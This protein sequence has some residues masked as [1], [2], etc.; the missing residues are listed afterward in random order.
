MSGPLAQ[1][2]HHTLL[3]RT[4]TMTDPFAHRPYSMEQQ[5]P[6][7]DGVTSRYSFGPNDLATLL[8]MPTVT[9]IQQQPAAFENG[10]LPE[11]ELRK[12]I[13]EINEDAALEPREKARRIQ[14]RQIYTFE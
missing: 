14:V 12:R 7:Q 9:N 3:Y 6:D 1:S 2:E 5:Q 13:R 10:R 11:A 8:N 4:T